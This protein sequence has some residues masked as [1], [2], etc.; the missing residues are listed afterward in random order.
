MQLVIDILQMALIVALGVVTI[1]EH[2]ELKA[3]KERT[4]KVEDK[5][6]DLIADGD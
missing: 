1:L 2:R 5:T 6:K 4:S 3:L